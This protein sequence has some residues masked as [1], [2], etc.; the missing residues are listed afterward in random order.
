MLQLAEDEEEAEPIDPADL[1]A[2]LEGWPQANRREFA[3]D[4]EVEA[5][6][7]RFDP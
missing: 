2:V 6:L 3:S 7:R 1:E 5:A 4:E